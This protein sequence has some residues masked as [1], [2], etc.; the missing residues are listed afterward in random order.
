[1]NVIESCSDANGRGLAADVVYLDIMEA[2]DG[3]PHK[4]LLEKMSAH[5]FNANFRNCTGDFL[6]GRTLEE[7]FD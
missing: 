4:R 6:T 3:V 1:M 5:N 7:G 2:Y